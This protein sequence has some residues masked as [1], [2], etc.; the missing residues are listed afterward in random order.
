[1]SL[2]KKMRTRVARKTKASFCPSELRKLQ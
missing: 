2:K 1:V